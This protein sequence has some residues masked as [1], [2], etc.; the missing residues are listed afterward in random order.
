VLGFPTVDWINAAPAGLIPHKT[1]PNVTRTS[2]REWD[3]SVAY[4]WQYTRSA[5]IGGPPPPPFGFLLSGGMTLDRL[6]AEDN[7]N[8]VSSL[9]NLQLRVTYT[10]PP[11][12]KPFI[13]PR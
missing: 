9:S 3:V 6:H 4:D 12:G 7:T 11:N 2:P 10:V 1:I 5:P 8:C 13:P